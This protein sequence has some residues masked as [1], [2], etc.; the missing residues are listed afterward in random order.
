MFKPALVIALFTFIV[1]CNPKLA[2]GLRKNDLKKDVEMVTDHGTIVIRLSDST[3]LH[4]DNFLRLVKQHFYDGIIFHR[5]IQNFMI[6]AGDAD[7]KNTVKT[8]DTTKRKAERTVP[9]EFVPSLFHHKG[10]IAAARMG[11]DVNPLKASS[12]TQFY[13]VQGKIFTDAGLDSVETLRLQGRKLPLQHREIY[14]TLGGT[15]HLDMNYT[16]FGNVISGL[17]VIDSIAA[18]KTSGKT[19]GDKPL[20][21]I[22]ILRSYLVK[23][24]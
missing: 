21:D 5:V 2:N 22:R 10:V 13:L 11:D 23:R 17:A 15:P 16:V 20:K 8:I 14:K 19:S 6:Q 3:P 12:E 24:K 9:S 4:R 1:S 7:T 18:E